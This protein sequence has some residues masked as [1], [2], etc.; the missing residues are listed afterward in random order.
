VVIS[1]S[2]LALL[3]L[4]LSGHEVSEARRLDDDEDSSGGISAYI[5]DPL[6]DKPYRQAEN[7]YWIFVHI[8]VIGYM[9]LGLNTVCDAYFTGALDT[10]VDRWNIKPDV[11]GATFMAAGGSAPE[12]FTSLIGTTVSESDVGFGT[13]VGS[14]VFNVLFVIGLC[15]AVASEPIKLT[16]WPLARDCS[17]YIVGLTMLAIFA[18]TG[19][20]QKSGNAIELWEAIILFLMYI[21]YCIL[22]YFNPKLEELFGVSPPDANPG[23][24]K[25]LEACSS[26]NDDSKLAQVVPMGDTGSVGLGIKAARTVSHG[27]GESEGIKSFASTKSTEEKRK[28]IKKPQPHFH[29]ANSWGAAER[30]K[31][32][33]SLAESGVASGPP[34]MLLGWRRSGTESRDV[35]QNQ[36]S[37]TLEASTNKEASMRT[38]TPLDDVEDEEENDI[39]ALVSRPEGTFATA[40]WILCLP[41]YG[42]LYYLTPK[43]TETWFLATF[44]ISLLWIAGFSFFLVYS[45]E[46][47]GE[48]LRIHIIVMGFTLL[49]AG[50]SIPDAVSSVAVARAGEGD[51]AIS[52]SIGSNIFDILVGLP[53]PWILKIGFI[54]MA[55]NGDHDFFVSI[56]SDYI[57]LYVLI[58]VFMVFSVVMS[59]HCLGWVLNRK[60][61]AGMGLLYAIFLVTVLIVEFERPEALRF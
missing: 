59:I 6:I 32:A 58:L 5:E 41:I 55:G 51:M 45:V 49:A 20:S 2:L 1:L 12:L 44:I 26:P 21:G 40:I 50:T 37:T 31:R 28:H 36:S 17:C 14:A 38:C 18:K 61:G 53:I 11:A 39:D 33:L 47:L 9:L 29:R 25:S 52:S 3:V 22:M 56:E 30:E 8:I 4:P 7:W 23:S 34:A 19:N 27:W 54:E 15:G 48:V 60:L 46:V 10:M 13:I 16:W 57:L 35:P 42:P 43:P 24:S